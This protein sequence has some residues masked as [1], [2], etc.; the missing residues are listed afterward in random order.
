MPWWLYVLYFFSL[1]IYCKRYNTFSKLIKNP[2]AVVNLLVMIY[3]I[4]KLILMR[5]ESLF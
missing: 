4:V 1:G 3:V 2:L 5:Y